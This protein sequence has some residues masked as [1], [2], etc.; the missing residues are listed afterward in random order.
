MRFAFAAV[1]A[2]CV[3]VVSAAIDVYPADFYDPSL[4]YMNL[5]PSTEG[6]KR[7]AQKSEGEAKRKGEYCFAAEWLT[8]R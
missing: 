1:L 7:T 6:L 8:D 3:A 4:R 5:G 2:L